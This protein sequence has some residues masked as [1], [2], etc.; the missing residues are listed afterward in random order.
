VRAKGESLGVPIKMGVMQRAERIMYLGVGCAISPILE[1]VLVPD[2]RRPIHRIAVAGIILLAVATQ[3]TALQ[4]IIALLGALGDSPLFLRRKP[5]KADTRRKVLASTLAALVDFAVLIGLVSAVRL[6][7][8][9]ATAIGGVVGGVVHWF[10]VRLY[11]YDGSQ[12]KL[13]QAGR[14]AFVNLTSAALC[15]GGVG[16]L[17]LLPTMDYRLAWVL[18]RIAVFIAWNFPLQRDYV[19]ARRDET[20]AADEG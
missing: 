16:L 7:A 18:V 20:A 3:L 19:F 4:R 11:A 9:T 8:P 1:A 13:P 6:G 14:Y 10:I 12:A 5:R 17:L 2:D 15:A